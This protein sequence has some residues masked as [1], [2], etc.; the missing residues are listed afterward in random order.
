MIVPGALLSMKIEVYIRKKNIIREILHSY[1]E[2]P[3]YKCALEELFC[4]VNGYEPCDGYI[5]NIEDPGY[6]ELYTRILEKINELR[7]SLPQAEDGGN[8]G[9]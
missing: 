6:R 1:K 5:S 8:T 9:E 3:R 7:A 2:L 4:A